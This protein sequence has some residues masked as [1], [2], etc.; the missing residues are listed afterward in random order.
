MVGSP[1]RAAA[2]DPSASV[3]VY[4]RLASLE[5]EMR[6]TT[7]T[8]AALRVRSAIIEDGRTANQTQM[9]QLEH[10]VGTLSEKLRDTL[11]ELQ[12][13]KAAQAAQQSKTDQWFTLIKWGLAVAVTLATLTG[14]I[15]PNVIESLVGGL[16]R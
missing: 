1:N 10:Q 15:P 5:A 13:S 6:S 4:E 3:E 7:E 14:K 8:I 16:H 12:A 11:A 2:R 9:L